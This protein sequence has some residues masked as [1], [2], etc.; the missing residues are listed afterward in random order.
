MIKFDSVAL[1]TTG[2]T[3]TDLK[4]LAKANYL[5]RT[6]NV[7]SSINLSRR[8]IHTMSCINLFL[9]KAIVTTVPTTTISRV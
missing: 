9:S 3:R 5:P 1:L 7:S 2:E 4:L 8:K 6:P